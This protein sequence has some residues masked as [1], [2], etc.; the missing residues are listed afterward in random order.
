M[1]QVWVWL[2]SESESESG[3]GMVAVRLLLHEESSFLVIPTIG[4]SAAQVWVGLLL[5]AEQTAS[6]F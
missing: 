4:K 1:V 6:S 2:Q 3:S 5:P